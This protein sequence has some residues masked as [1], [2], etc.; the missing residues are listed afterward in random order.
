MQRD[1]ADGPARLDHRPAALDPRLHVR[2]D[3][4]VGPARAERRAADR[5]AEH[6]AVGIVA[7]RRQHL[8]V[9]G[10][11]N[12]RAGPDRRL[13]A[14]IDVD[15]CEVEVERGKPAR[16]RIDVGAR[17]DGGVG[18]HVH[19]ADLAHVA[20]LDAVADQGLGFAVDADARE[21]RARG[22]RAH[23]Y[24]DGF[25]R[26]RLARSRGHGDRARVVQALRRRG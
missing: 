23:G 15:E 6:L 20:H 10:G 14:R 21:R 26:H 4:D 11:E 17:I 24:A 2:L 25:G 8:D 9:A 7:G 1:D 16:N 13:D 18:A 12:A 22:D 19:A 3:L 5:K